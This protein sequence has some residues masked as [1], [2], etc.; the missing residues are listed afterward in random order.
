[1]ADAPTIAIGDA[2]TFTT[3]GRFPRDRSG[4]VIGIGSD[5]ITIQSDDG[6]VR[7]SR[8]GAVKKV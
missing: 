1:M 7:K 6:P 3:P 4:K 8:P 2:V 5:F